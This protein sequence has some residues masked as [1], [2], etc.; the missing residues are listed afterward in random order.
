MWIDNSAL[1][2]VQLILSASSMLPSD[3]ERYEMT[4]D[5]QFEI[6]LVWIQDKIESNCWNSNSRSLCEIYQIKEFRIKFNGLLFDPCHFMFLMSWEI[7]A[8]PRKKP[9]RSSLKMKFEDYFGKTLFRGSK[10]TLKY[11]SFF[12]A[13]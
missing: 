4:R 1:A 5:K 13:R 6:N 9:S 7:L 11:Q 3:R 10:T 8:S 2:P 12:H